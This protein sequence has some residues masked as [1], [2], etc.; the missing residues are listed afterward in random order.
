MKRKPT[1]TEI[2]FVLSSKR[3]HKGP[4]CRNTSL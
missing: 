2:I 3:P 1:G 4:C